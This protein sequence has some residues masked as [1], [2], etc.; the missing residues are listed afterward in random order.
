VSHRGVTLVDARHYEKLIPKEGWLPPR[1]ALD[2]QHMR[3]FRGFPQEPEP[4]LG[5]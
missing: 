2:V 5:Q 4:L 3:M 1:A